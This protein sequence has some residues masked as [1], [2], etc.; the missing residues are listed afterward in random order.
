MNQ[1]LKYTTM[2]SPVGPLVLAGDE[3][4]LTLIGFTT[5]PKAS[6]IDPDWVCEPTAFEA[7]RTQLKEYFAGQRQVFDLTLRPEGTE[8]Q[9]AVWQALTRIPYGETCSYGE[10]ATAIGRPKAVR[11][12]GAAN[13]RNPLPIVVPCHRVIGSNGSL[14]GFGG[15]LENKEWLLALESRRED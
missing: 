1:P 5:G 11:A 13:G 9:R 12:V 10:I 4:A 3:T 15:G 8:F 6:S 14:T 7:V 2:D